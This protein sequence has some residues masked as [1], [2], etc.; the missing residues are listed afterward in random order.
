MEQ[1]ADAI[2]AP[3]HVKAAVLS[4]GELMARQERALTAHQRTME[5]LASEL[6]RPRSVYAVAAFGGAWIVL[7]LLLPVAGRVAFDPYPFPG[8]A[9]LLTLAAFLMTVV[10][11]T[12][13]NRLDADGDERSRLALQMSILTEQKIAKVIE[14]IEGLRRDD[15]AVVDRVDPEAEEMARSADPAE[16]LG[17][18]DQAH[19]TLMEQE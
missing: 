14:L 19:R 10:I 13:Q 18:M 15:P 12:A 7:N 11:L 16:V 2:D 1:A 8:L 5:R 3:D 4:V 17:Q 9:G 6:G